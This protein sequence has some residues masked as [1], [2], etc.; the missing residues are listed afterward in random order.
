MIKIVII[1]ICLVVSLNAFER[2]VY[3]NIHNAVKY[4]KLEVLKKLSSEELTDSLVYAVRAGDFN[5]VKSLVKAGS[6]INAYNDSDTSA[7]YE[8]FRSERFN[9]VDYLLTKGAILNI[10]A[11]YTG[12]YHKI[13]P[14]LFKAIHN[15]NIRLVKNLLKYGININVKNKYNKTPLEYAIERKKISISEY[16]KKLKNMNK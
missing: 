16:F 14:Y 7:L 1:F 2:E 3:D 12:E 11:N 15:N 13:E 5:V 9:I 4:K 10:K 8:A 6:N